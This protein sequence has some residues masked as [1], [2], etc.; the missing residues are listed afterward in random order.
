VDKEHVYYKV[1][2]RPFSELM[3]IIDNSFRGAEKVINII[4]D[5]KD[6]DLYEAVIY[7]IVEG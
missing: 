6:D 2:T 1:I 4:V 7:Y 5:R 3:Y